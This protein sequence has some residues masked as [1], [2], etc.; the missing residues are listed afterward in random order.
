[1]IYSFLF[2]YSLISSTNF[3][4]LFFSFF[5]IPCSYMWYLVKTALLSF[6]LSFFPS[7]FPSFFRS[8]FFF[9]PLLISFIISSNFN[10]CY[11]NYHLVI[12]FF[13][14]TSKAGLK[15]YGERGFAAVA[16]RQWNLIP[17]EL[18]SS[19]S[20]DIFKRH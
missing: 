7:C 5:C 14:P 12:S 17:L 1:M 16:S 3:L 10:Y 8:F 9:L 2:I 13:F 20:I 11:C 15:T 4:C 6:F 19:S 18:R